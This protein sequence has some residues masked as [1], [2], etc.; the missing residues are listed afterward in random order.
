VTR[1]EYIAAFPGYCRECEGWGVLKMLS[2][3][4][5][6]RDCACVA[7]DNCPRCG[8][9]PLDDLRVCSACQ[10]HMD[11]KERGIPGPNVI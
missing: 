11:E 1:Q 10:W 6:F 3:H 9:S 2:S 8:A 5:T 4:V 7:E